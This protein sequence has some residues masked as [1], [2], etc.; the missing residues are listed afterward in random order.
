MPGRPKTRAKLYHSL[1]QYLGHEIITFRDIDTLVKDMVGKEIN[2][3][4]E[5]INPLVTG[6]NR[7]KGP[8]GRKRRKA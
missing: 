6:S 4:G 8:A 2:R 5:D 3:G 7:D 1:Q